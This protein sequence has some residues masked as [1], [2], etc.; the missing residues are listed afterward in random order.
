MQNLQTGI[1]KGLIQLDS[2]Q[3]NITYI[4]CNKKYRFSDPEEKV[5]AETYIKLIL[6]YGYD[7]KRIDLEVKVPHRTPNNLADIVVFSDDSLKEPYIVVECKKPD[8]SEAEFRQAIEQGFG[9]ANSIKATF[10]WVCSGLKEEFFNVADFPSMERQDNRIADIPEFGEKHAKRWKYTRG[11]KDGF[12]L[13]IVEQ[14]ELTRIFKKAHDSLWAGGKRNPAEAFDELSKLIFCKILD[15][16][17]PRKLGEPY[18]FQAFTGENKNELLERVKALYQKGQVKDP[19]VFKD[20]IRLTPE[21]LQT[22]VGY[23]APINLNKTDLDSKGRAM[24]TFMGD[25]FRGEFG[26]YFTPRPIVQFII[27]SLPFPDKRH[28]QLVLDPACGSG[29]FLLYFL[30]AVRHTGLDYYESDSKEHIS[31]WHNFAEKRLFGIEISESIARTAKMNMILHDDGHTNVVSFDGLALPETIESATK[32]HDFKENH[33]DLIA[34][35]PPFGSDVKNSEKPYMT[36]YELG[37]KGAD[38]IEAKLKNINLNEKDARER[39]STEIMFLEQC[40]RFLK[41]DGILAVV[42]PDGILTNLS[43]QYVRDWIE[44]YWRILAVVSMPQT[45][46]TATGAGVKSSVVFLRKYSVETTAQ[47]RTIKSDI[48]DSLFEQPE[49]YDE[50][51]RLEN[52]K[53][54]VLK[55]G[56]VECQRIEQDLIAHLDTLRNQKSLDKTIQKDLER[57]AK[58]ERKEY[59]KTEVF[60]TW[61]KETGDNFNEQIKAVKEALQDA[62]LEEI[63]AKIGDYPIFMAIAEDIGYDATGRS[64]GNNELK[65]I[66]QELRRFIESVIDRQDDFFQLALI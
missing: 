11:G 14:S 41:T 44:E 35:N 15:E 3:K 31:Y 47:I 49:Y 32:N 6:E 27:D 50:I 62:A 63:K 55:R 52:E 60:K 40:H 4:A 16:R 20:D 13:E 36:E 42:I 25:F 45:A 53:K 29:G 21:E 28:E 30:D 19:E 5:R 17:E 8:I 18:Q 1:D 65:P 58:S 33:F 54:R 9:N 57:K 10:L 2:P 64:T 23:L 26:Q 39:Q 66:S 34:T 46:F 37:C 12:E 38:W 59:E 48:R 61:K 56:D 24:E 7:T 22:V 51:V 43:L